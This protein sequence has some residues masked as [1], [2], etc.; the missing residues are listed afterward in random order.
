MLFRSIVGHVVPE[1]AV[2]GP[3]ALVR[4]GDVIT[5]SAKT[6]T[7]SM[8]VSDEE[9]EERRKGWK[10][11]RS[12]VNRGVLAKYQALVG[13]ASEGAMTDLF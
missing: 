2:G 12:L 9:L 13:N 11:P 7:I 6:N 4:D 5:I 1:A 10:P 8:D 3:I